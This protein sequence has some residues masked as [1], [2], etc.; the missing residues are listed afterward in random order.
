M[1]KYEY[2]LKDLDCAACG[3]KIQ[4]KIATFDEYDNVVVNY[5]TLKLSFEIKEDAEDK[6]IKEK[7]IEIVSGVEPEVEILEIEEYEALKSKKENHNH[8]HEHEN[9]D[10][11]RNIRRIIIAV[12]IVFISFVVQVILPNNSKVI[13]D[14]L[15]G[16][17]YII[18]LWRTGKNAIK[19][20]KKKTIDENFLITIS[21]IGA[22][23]IDK[24]FEGFMVIFLYEIGKILEDKAVNNTRKSIADLMDIKP[25]YANLKHDDGDIHVIS[26][27]KVNV[28]DIII[29]KQGEKIPLDAVVV[30]GEASLNVSSL[31]G[32]SALKKVKKD[33]EI[34][35]GS[36]NELGM[37][38]ARVIKEYKDSTVS[39]ILELVENATD[40]KSKTETFVN[41]ASRIY[42]PIVVA[43]ALL[44]FTLLP[45][46]IGITYAEAFYRSLIFLVVS[47][48]CAIVISVPLSY[49]TGIG[50]ASKKGILIKGSNYLDSIQKIRKIIFD[51]TGTL[52]KGEFELEKVVSLDE[53]Y[54]KDDLLKIVSA[55][56]LF[57]N[58]PI[59]KAIV[60]NNINSIEKENVH[61]FS[62]ISG[63][64][65][66]FSYENKKV[67]V[68]NIELIKENAK[69]D[70]IELE[71]DVGTILFICIDSS[72]VGYILLNDAIKKESKELIKKLKMRNINVSMFTGDNLN[73]ALRVAKA[74]DIT[75]IKAEMLPQDKYSEMEKIISEE[76]ARGGNVAF[77]GD[78]INDSPVLALSD[79]GISMGGV[80]ASSAVEA[81]D[82]VIM[83][84][85]L[86]RIY[87]AIKI[88]KYT[89][90]IIKQNLIFALSI[91]VLV[92]I[93][94]AFGIAMMWQA[95]FADVGVTLITILNTLR[96]LKYED[97][98]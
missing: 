12:A 21:C 9:V 70:E 68:G 27:D 18:L 22:F 44:I 30:S 77:V 62:E 7:I 89:G 42:T 72:Y 59:A 8:I 49:F 87:D 82:V 73:I 95:V 67:L 38:E 35:S 43:L 65:I 85:D 48:P 36:I 6:L 57:S 81:S 78:G 10:F 41:R 92:L 98:D 93:L 86:N 19:L 90:K 5:N 39:K 37:V 76:H 69:I 28:G 29:I 31:T 63:K 34:L 15:L 47:C 1:K 66:S 91:K 16:I 50:K 58:H 45:Q 33:D 97:F 46:L 11:M 83:T 4:D 84:D 80:G 96:I 51:K 26:P 71:E 25:E 23:F 55:G 60:K 14:V 94:S 20:I 54:S 2:I 13:C 17:A 3:I 40:K 74:I 32:E 79:I 53:K 52:T 24:K 61:E 88:S 64:G 75:D 56:E